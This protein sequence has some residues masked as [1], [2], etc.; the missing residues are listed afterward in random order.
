MDQRRFRSLCG[1]G[2]F[3]LA[4]GAN[5]RMFIAAFSGDFSADYVLLRYI[6]ALVIGYVGMRIM[7]SILFRPRRPT[8]AETTAPVEAPTESNA[9]RS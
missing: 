5:G 2:I 6:A 9:E 8:A 4:L 3:L 1:A 7:D